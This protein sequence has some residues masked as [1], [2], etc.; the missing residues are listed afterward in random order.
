VHGRFPGLIRVRWR[1]S[2]RAG[3]GG[4]LALLAVACGADD[5]RA[6]GGEPPSAEERLLAWEGESP[7]VPV[8]VALGFGRPIPDSALVTL[9]TRHRLRPYALYLVAGGLASEQRVPRSEASV[10]LVTRAREEALG[11][12]RVSLCAQPDRARA[13]MEDSPALL[14]EAGS[15]R[16]AAVLTHVDHLQEDLHG[17]ATGAPIFYG[18]EVVGSPADARASRDESLLAS[19]EPAVWETVEGERRPVLTAPDLES[20]WAD[21]GIAPGYAEMAPAEL[22]E[23]FQELARGI[24][25]CDGV[26]PIPR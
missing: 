23:H 9:L 4:G 20:G 7:E 3:I 12:L 18:A 16:V 10:E 1:G 5:D 19:F 24:Q 21:R 11:Q 22:Q 26:E 14:E 2:R 17:L 15:A 8:P 13:M 25:G 6:S